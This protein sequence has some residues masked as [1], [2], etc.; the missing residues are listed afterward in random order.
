V[1][2]DS[3]RRGVKRIFDD[4]FDRMK[5]ISLLLSFVFSALMLQAQTPSPTIPSF[6]FVQINQQPFTQANLPAKKLLFFFFFDPGCDHCQRTMKALDQRAGEV[7]K[8]SVFLVSMDQ[9][10]K[11][12]AFLKA[13]A[14]H[15]S[16]QKNVTILQDRAYQFITRFQ[17][18]KY[19]GLFVYGPDRAL[20]IYADEEQALPKVL[21]SIKGAPAK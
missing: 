18:K 19:P 2:V 10:P 5:K 21:A 9:Q 15:L 17:P 11:M 14:P 1:F 4:I 8:A 7:S 13:Y 3:V 20:K 12:Q 16:V 6:S